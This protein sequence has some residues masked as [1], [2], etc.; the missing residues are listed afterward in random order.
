MRR[1]LLTIATSLAIAASTAL[2]GT[3]ASGASAAAGSTAATSPFSLTRAAP[4]ATAGPP[5]TLWAP[6]KVTAEASG[7]RVWVDLGV[8]LVAGSAPFELRST[9]ASY[10]DP[11][12]TTW[13]SPDG[14]VELPGVRM[15]N[16]NGRLPG[17]VRLVIRDRRGTVVHRET[18]GGCL[19]SWST[20]RVRPDAPA[21]SP[22]PQSCYGSLYSL[23]AVQGVQTGWAS[24]LSDSGRRL[25]L[26]PG[27]Y[28]V[29]A[30]L[31]AAYAGPLGLTPAQS[32][33]TISLV[34]RRADHDGD[35]HAHGRT[36]RPDGAP[37]APSPVP[38]AKEP[39]SR[40]AGEP[41]DVSPDLRS[42][43]AFGIRVSRNGDFLQF[44]ATVWNAGN[45]PLV[46]DGFRREGEDLMDG[47]QY[48]FDSDGEQTGYQKVGQ[49]HWH[50]APTH[51]HWHF[52]DFARYSL[53][54]AD[55]TEAVRSRKQS[56]C[57]ANT[58]MVNYTVPGADW[59]PDRTDLDTAC[60]EQT[61]LSIR[62]VLSAGSGDTY[63]QYRAGQSFNLRALPNG[64]YHIAVEGNPM[65]RLVE[66]DLT[67][68]LALRR[69]RIGGKPG[70]RTVKVSKVGI[71]DEPAEE[72]GR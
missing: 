59:Q 22:Y 40:A 3:G 12:V 69:I 36:A 34:V 46:V 2:V 41:G 60:G 61:S 48:F 9:R 65:Q 45:S 38:A 5:A 15:K 55:R 11:I 52:L 6:H 47:Y 25:P 56:F 50:D 24:P 19:N 33:R 23:G 21:R 32:Q 44:S 54:R 10:S 51:Q 62:E 58:D 29:T 28:Q 64:V 53:L 39:T 49:L 43:P 67:N 35:G 42:L 71:I 17:M 8:R 14:P 31:G 63:M 1:P 26:K 37:S 27:T 18:R 72:R 30:S 68:N 20:E 70:A 66:S 57:L 13:H 16:F 7:K 4:D